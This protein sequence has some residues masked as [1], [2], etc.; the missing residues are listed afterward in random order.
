MTDDNLLEVRAGRTVYY[1][2]LTG[3]TDDGWPRDRGWS[4]VRGTM[5]GK[6]IIENASR[7]GGIRRG[8]V[9][10]E[11]KTLE[12]TVRRLLGQYEDLPPVFDPTSPGWAFRD[13]L[14]GLWS[15]GTSPAFVG[16]KGWGKTKLLCDLCAALIIPGRRFLQHFDPVQVTDEERGRDV[17]LLNSETHHDV[18]HRELLRCGLVFG[19]RDARTPCYGPSLEHIADGGG[20]LIVEQLVMTSATAFDLTD[21]AKFDNWVVRLTEYTNHHIP[22]LT[23]IADGVTAMLGNDTGRYGKWTFNFKDLL[24]EC[25]IPNG[26]GCLHSPMGVRTNTPMNGIESMAQWD[27]MWM[28]SSPD[29]PVRSG[30]ERWLERLPRLGD[31][32]WPAR[33]IV[34]DEDG[35]LRFLPDSEAPG[36]ADQPT[37]QEDRENALLDKLRAG[38]PEGMWTRDLC[39]TGDDYTANKAALDALKDRGVVVAEPVQNGRSRGVRWRLAE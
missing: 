38:P 6:E 27:G 2:E 23:V 39:G 34:M 17:W 26:L 11:G 1:P 28:G 21:E 36:P 25:A 10:L 24:K 7:S 22:P 13:Y 5:G 31:D 4:K 19:Y 20:V 35:L 32:G 8:G 30:S 12:R 14:P 29:W 18:I 37:T 16:P 9:P 15:H 3:L 33:R